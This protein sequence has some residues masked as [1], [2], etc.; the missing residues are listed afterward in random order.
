MV[1]HNSAFKTFALWQAL[2]VPVVIV[3]F[4]GMG[5]V[6]GATEVVTVLVALVSL[7]YFADML[8][9]LFLV[10]SSL[11]HSSEF[12]VT[13]K[14]MAVERDWP[15]YTVFCPLYKETSVLKQFT[16]AMNKLDYP[17]DKLRIMLLLEEDDLETINAARAMGLAKHFEIV[18]VPHSLPKTKP[19]ACNYGLTLTHSEY[20]VI[21]DAEDIP[22]RNQL[23]KA[24][25]S[26]ENAP[27]DI[28]CIQAKLNFYNSTQNMLTRMFTAEYS[29]W[30][31]LTLVG[32]QNIKGPVPLGGTSNHFK[33]YVLKGLY[34]W[35]PYNV[36]EDCDL[37]I[38]LYKQGFRT[39]V[40]DSY[41]LE[42]ANSKYGNWL[43]QR[44]RWI[45][46]Y[47]QTFLVH[48]RNPRQIQKHPLDMHI[49]TFY[50]VVGGKVLS[51]LA[52]P[53]MWL[54]TLSYFILKPIVGATIESI[55]PTPIFY[56]ALV[57]LVFG[58]LLYL[59]YFMLGTAQREQWNLIK[60]VVIVPLYW[61]MMSI[62]GFYALYQLIVKPHYWEKTTHGL[63]LAKA[64]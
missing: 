27:G 41:T 16:T 59:Y 22:A 28:A 63:H 7:L 6:V 55:Y 24:V 34:G 5:L 31:N 53:L 42:E 32:L 21:F 12:K 48:T 46:G 26:F 8:F 36:T 40:L 10:S 18:V 60:F 2:V 51:I 4:V 35:D 64:K 20:C 58:N 30:F 25:I 17:K 62:A 57:T 19:K 1:K 33:T 43:R 52:N 54:L 61:L 3:I 47:M 29:L 37:G 49:F 9:N 44:S 13:A 45:K 23:K 11:S 56:I 14:Q 39:G 38:R 15:T 50:L